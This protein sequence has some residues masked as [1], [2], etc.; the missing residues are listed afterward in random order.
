MQFTAT[1]HGCKKDGNFY[2]KK[3]NIF[4]IFAQNIDREAILTST[5]D[6]CFRAQIRKKGICICRIHYGNT[7]M[8]FTATF[9]GCK[10]W[11]FSYEKV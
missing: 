6:I 1:F 8:Q 10:K 3:C 7:H 4:L 2:M 5:H 9:H 11:Q